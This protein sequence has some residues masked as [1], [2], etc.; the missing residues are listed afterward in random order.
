VKADGILSHERYIAGQEE[1]VQ[2]N[3]SGGRE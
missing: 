1:H 3:R 2:M